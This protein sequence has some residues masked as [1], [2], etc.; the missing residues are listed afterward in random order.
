[1]V[2]GSAGRTRGT[3]TLPLS[4]GSQ[5]SPEHGEERH[6]RLADGIYPLGLASELLRQFVEPITLWTYQHLR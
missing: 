3:R 5:R 1:M 4:V 2:S 6:L